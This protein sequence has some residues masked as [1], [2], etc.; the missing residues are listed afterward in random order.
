[1]MMMTK[2]RKMITIYDEVDLNDSSY[3]LWNMEMFVHRNRIYKVE[4]RIVVMHVEWLEIPNP[5][6]FHNPMFPIIVEVLYH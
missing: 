6:H 1:M 5:Y 3:Y 2:K 4:N